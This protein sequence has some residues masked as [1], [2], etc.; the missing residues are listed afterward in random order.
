MVR[1]TDASAIIMLLALAFATAAPALLQGARAPADLARASRVRVSRV[2][3]AATPDASRRE[4]LGAALAAVPAAMLASGVAVP[5]VLADDVAVIQPSTS[6]MGGLLDAYS[7]V[8]KGWS[9]YKPSTWNKFDAN[10]GEYEA[11]WQDIV[12]VTE[13]ILV[14][15]S[16]VTAGKNIDALGSPQELG[17]K[18]AKLRSLSL[19]SAKA[20]K[21]GPNLC[22][23]VELEG[24]G[25]HELILFTVSKGR[26]WRVTAKASNAKWEKNKEMYMTVLTSF[27][28]KIL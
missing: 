28:T 6:R 3:A 1:P 17:E 9:I 21:L 27:Q 11:K 20:F 14:S 8:G 24:S 25:G 23:L 2:Q 7:D 15:S 18:V 12:G 4:A 16:P 22:Y 26:L 10:P 13:Q 19:D 5:A